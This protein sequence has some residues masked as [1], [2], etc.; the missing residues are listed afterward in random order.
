MYKVIRWLGPLLP[1]SQPHYLMGVGEP[2]DIIEAVNWGFDMFDCVLPT[3]LGRHGTVW[4]TANW[5]TFR[6]I[7]LRKTQYRQDKRVIMKDCYCPACQ[8]GYS[9]AYIGHLVKSSEMLGMRLASLH[10]LWIIN[11]LLRRIRKNI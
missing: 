10:N 3:R 2:K 9:R 8:N 11:E 5:Q 6:K 1:K 4:V 7:D